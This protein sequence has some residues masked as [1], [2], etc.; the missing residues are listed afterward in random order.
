MRSAGDSC[1]N[2]GTWGLLRYLL[3]SYVGC[4]HALL[5]DGPVSSVAYAGS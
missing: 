5:Y 1:V 4:S 3:D 2:E